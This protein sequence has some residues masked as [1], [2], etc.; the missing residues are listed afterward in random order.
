MLLYPKLLNPEHSLCYIIIKF[1]EPIINNLRFPGGSD[2]KESFYNV[3]DVGSIPGLGRS[4]GGGHGNP[5][6][7]RS[8]AIPM[9][10]E[11]WRA[12]VHGV[13]ESWTRLRD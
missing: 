8:L 13:T 5:H 10:R 7:Q 2:G 1:P 12:T 6:G 4:P 3:G 9:D 11:A